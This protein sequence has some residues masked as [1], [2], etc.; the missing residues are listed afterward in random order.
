ML[1]RNACLQWQKER[2]FETTRC[3]I[4]DKHKLT[5]AFT[6]TLRHASLWLTPWMFARRWKGTLKVVTDSRARAAPP[7]PLRTLPAPRGEPRNYDSPSR[8]KVRRSFW[9]TWRGGSGPHH[10]VRG[11]GRRKK[12]KPIAGR[13][14][15]TKPLRRR[16]GRDDPSHRLRGRPKK[17]IFEVIVVQRVRYN[18]TTHNTHIGVARHLEPRRCRPR[19]L[20]CLH[21]DDHVRKAAASR[22]PPALVTL[23]LA[24]ATS[25]GATGTT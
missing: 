10:V 5:P 23:P 4:V 16:Q 14:L 20:K 9:R 21:D 8:K 2:R 11:Q 22:R 18:R 25:I 3:Q 12:R 19:T 1:R 13:S 7:P 17:V 15:Q 6:H 24:S